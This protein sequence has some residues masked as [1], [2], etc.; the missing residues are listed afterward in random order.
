MK[1]LEGLPLLG[2]MTCYPI[3]NGL[4]RPEQVSSAGGTPSYAADS[5]T[6]DLNQ[7]GLDYILKDDSST[8]AAR[9]HYGIVFAVMPWKQAHFNDGF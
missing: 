4:G 1:P 8:K 6:I 2:K 7:E 5:R 9:T 3:F